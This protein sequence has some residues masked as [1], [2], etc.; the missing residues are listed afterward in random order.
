VSRPVL[1][2]ATGDDA[3]RVRTRLRTNLVAWLTT[4]DRHGQPWTA[5]VW[6]LHRADGTLLVY[7]R[8]GSRRL[9]HLETNP[10][11]SF[12]LDVSDLGRDLAV[13]RGEARVAPEESGAAENPEF[14]DKYLERAAAM[15]GDLETYAADFTVPIVVVPQRIG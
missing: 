7:S 8:P 4:V 5:P 6:F 10:R 2:P 11:V 14:R 1:P 3:D 9:R 12:A 13:G 15:F